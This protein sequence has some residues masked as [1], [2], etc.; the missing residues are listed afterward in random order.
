MK[1]FFV[2]LLALLLAAGAAVAIQYDSGYVLIAYG[3]TTVEMTLWIAVAVLLILLGLAWLLFSLLRRGAKLS[4]RFGNFRGGQQQ[5]RSERGREQGGQET[6]WGRHAR[7]SG[8]G[9]SHPPCR[10]SRHPAA[11]S[12]NPHAGRAGERQR[13]VVETPYADKQPPPRT[14]GGFLVNPSHA[15]PSGRG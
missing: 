11:L 15:T 2:A 14:T 6:A 5:R 12:T 8:R 10:G 3:H 4:D 1:L 9:S 13:A 7:T